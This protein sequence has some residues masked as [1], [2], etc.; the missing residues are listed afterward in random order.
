[1]DVSVWRSDVPEGRFQSFAV[2]VQ[3]SQTILDVVT[4]IQRHA[5]PTLAYRFAC[6][7][8][9]C[10][11]CAMMVN[12]EP[13]WTCRTHVQTVL[14]NGRLEIAPLR[15][16]PVIRD[17]VTDMTEFFDKWVSAEG[18]FRP[19]RTRKAEIAR[20]GPESPMRIEANAGIECI[21]CAVCY[22]AC[23]VVADNPNYLGPAALNRAWT[24]VNDARDGA[25]E[26]RLAAVSLAGGCHNCH[27]IGSCSLY[28][29]NQI[30]PMASIAGLKRETVRSVFRQR[31]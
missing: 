15:N 21:N 6:R 20:I 28:C 13:R 11:S 8:G 23:D 17:L 18:V 27:S 9:M 4:W 25:G 22:A 1:M 5:D 10:G 19:T 29:P 16:L 14:K 3:E 26:A 24:L 12:G 7:V 30:N 31:R 2:P